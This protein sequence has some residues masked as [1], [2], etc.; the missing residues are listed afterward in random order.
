MVD[1]ESGLPLFNGFACVE[2]QGGRYHPARIAFELIAWESQEILRQ[3]LVEDV[4]DAGQLGVR[5]GLPPDL[6]VELRPFGG[7]MV[8][9]TPVL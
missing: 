4:H 3:R 6:A 1:D 7:A 9:I 2:C 8:A 5:G